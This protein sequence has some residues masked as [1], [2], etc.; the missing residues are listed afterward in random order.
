MLVYCTIQ[1]KDHVFPTFD[2][3]Q[4]YDGDGGAS[5]RADR[6]GA[7]EHRSGLIQMS[8]VSEH[9]YLKPIRHDLLLLTRSVDHDGLC[10]H[11]T[12]FPL[13]ITESPVR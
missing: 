11:S 2:N 6:G 7:H 5:G 12:S 9:K 1:F 10:I 4:R 13:N 8:W 3:V